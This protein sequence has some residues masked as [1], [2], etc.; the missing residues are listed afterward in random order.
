MWSASRPRSLRS[1]STSRNESEYRSYSR[2]AQRIRPGPVCRHLKIAARIVFFMTS[3]DYQPPSAK[4]ATQ[5]VT[6]KDILGHAYLNTLEVYVRADL[7]MRRQA[8]EATYSPVQASLRAPRTEPDL[9]HWLE[10]L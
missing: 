6:I 2:T 3:S 1:S 8:L 10:Q 9:M 5:P 4:V 7:E